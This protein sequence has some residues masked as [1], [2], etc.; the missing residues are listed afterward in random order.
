MARNQCK[1]DENTKNQ[2]TSPPMDHNSSPAR[3][4]S[5]MENE[6]G[7]ALLPRLECSGMN[8]AHCNLCIPGSSHLPTSAFLV[9]G[10]TGMHHHAGLIFVFFIE[11]SFTMLPRLVLNFTWEA[12]AGGSQGYEFKTSLINMTESCSVAQAGVQWHNLGSLQP[13]PPGFKPF[14]C[15]SLLSSWDYRRA[16]PRLA[17]ICIFSKD[18]KTWEVQCS[19]TVILTPWSVSCWMLRISP[20]EKHQGWARWLTPII[21]A[22]W[23]AEAGGS[24]DQEIK[25]ILVNMSLALSPRLES[26]GMI[27]AHGNLRLLGSSDSPTS[28]SRRQNLTL[29]PKL[30]CSGTIMAHCRLQT[31]RLK[32]TLHLNI[33]K[34]LRK[35]QLVVND[36][37]DHDDNDDDDDEANE[38]NNGEDDGDDENDTTL[39]CHPAPIKTLEPSGQTHRRPDVERSPLAE[40]HTNMALAGHLRDKVGHS[41]ES[42]DHRA[43]QRKSISFLVPPSAESY[44]H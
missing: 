15:L 21:P 38:D 18:R 9:A 6:Q 5:W 30:E 20:L 27:L 40:E 31:P 41:E 16:P 17:N 42:L 32:Q 43:A 26:N 4:Q 23:E 8:L 44:F 19:R 29:S 11:R 28:A 39:A 1:K 13:L 2:N 25:T 3:E 12:K 22:L 7:L 36:D 14:S 24:L 34:R 35:E 37:E 10:T 33:P